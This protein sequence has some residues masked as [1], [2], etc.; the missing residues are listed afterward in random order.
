MEWEF[1]A[2]DVVKGDVGY[3]LCDFRHDLVREL[4]NNLDVA[5]ERE[6]ERAYAVVYDL[7]YALATGRTLEEFLA[8]LG[9]DPAA[10]RL[11]MHVREPM[12][13]NVEMLGAILQRM[14]MV[15]VESGLP[16][17]RALE[18][19]DREHADVASRPP[20]PAGAVM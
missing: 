8:T 7:C 18:A 11:A 16:L 12:A 15:G 9:G 19:A 5:D 1:T 17:E 4:R 2:E 14:I 3:A 6:F 10:T 13:P 20:R